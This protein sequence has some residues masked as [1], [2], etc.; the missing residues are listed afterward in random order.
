MLPIYVISLT[1]SRGRRE[2]IS[3][4]ATALNL[5]IQIIDAVDGREGFSTEQEK[6]IDRGKA[7]ENLR[8][9][10]TD[11][12]IACALSHALL[13]QKIAMDPNGNGAVILED[14]AILSS[15]FG[16]IIHKAALEN[17]GEDML[18]FHHLNAQVLK[19][20]PRTFFANIKLRTL[21]RPPYRTTGYYVSKRG[22][23]VLLQMSLPIASVADWGGDITKIGAKALDPTVI[24]HPPET[25]VPSTL[26]ERRTG[27]SGAERSLLK[28]I[29]DPIYRRYALR[30]LFSEY[31]S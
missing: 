8:K 28:K 19:Y 9:D 18:L 17:S 5:D 31:I 21:I 11:G 29:A 20:K 13:Y 1:D 14:D 3:R 6:Q 10:L 24:D 25:E 30:K 22:A 23:K 16:Q 27:K 12:E 7:R 4:Q 26:I 2:E 15:E